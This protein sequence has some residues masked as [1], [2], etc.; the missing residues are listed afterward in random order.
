VPTEFA[1][2]QGGRSVLKKKSSVYLCVMLFEK[3]VLSRNKV[4]KKQLVR[5]IKLCLFTCDA[6]LFALPV[7]S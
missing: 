7:R 4:N 6:V 2:V 3:K 1:L 5:N